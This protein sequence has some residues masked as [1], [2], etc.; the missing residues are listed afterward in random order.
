MADQYLKGCQYG[1][2]MITRYC[3]SL[4][5]DQMEVESMNYLETA[6]LDL[7]GKFVPLTNSAQLSSEDKNEAG[8]P[9]LDDTELT[10]SGAQSREDG[11]DDGDW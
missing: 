1:A 9:R 11:V 7:P 4:G 10:D 3:A 6:L 2:P 5:I 8:R